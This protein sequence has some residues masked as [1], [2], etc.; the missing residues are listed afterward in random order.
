MGA[1][2]RVLRLELV[3]D[4]CGLLLVGP[5]KQGELVRARARVDVCEERPVG[6]TGRT[7]TDFSV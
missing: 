1:V 4:E 3:R 6:G 5:R 2:V 7:Q